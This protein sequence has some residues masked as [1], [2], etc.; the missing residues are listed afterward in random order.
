MPNLPQSRGAQWSHFAG[1]KTES[2]EGPQQAQDLLISMST[3][4]NNQGTGHKA[5]RGLW[6]AL[7]SWKSAEPLNSRRTKGK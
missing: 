2:P 5:K 3:L 1:Q 4:G 6:A 7:F